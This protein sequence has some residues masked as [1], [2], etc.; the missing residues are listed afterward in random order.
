L[1]KTQKYREA[2]QHKMQEV[3]AQKVV[4]KEDIAIQNQAGNPIFD[5]IKKAIYAYT[6]ISI[7]FIDE[8]C[9]ISTGYKHPEK[10]SS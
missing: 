2:V 6:F 5:L 8:F 4:K 3:L 10:G 1:G 7:I 9:C